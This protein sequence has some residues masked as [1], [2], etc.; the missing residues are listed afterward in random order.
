MSSRCY[1]SVLNPVIYRSIKIASLYLRRRSER[2]PRSISRST[3][4]FSTP[5][6]F[7]LDCQL[8]HDTSLLGLDTPTNPHITFPSN[9]LTCI[10]S[11]QNVRPRQSQATADDFLRYQLW[12][13]VHIRLHVARICN[14]RHF[15]DEQTHQSFGG[16]TRSE[17]Y[18]LIVSMQGGLGGS[19]VGSELLK[20][21]V[22]YGW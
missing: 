19:M 13:V 2:H 22:R 11:P 4:I 17:G 14:Q 15:Q 18:E 16:S 20:P 8:F 21:A 12:T 6:T 10:T 9:L 7:L 1:Y 3:T 5:A